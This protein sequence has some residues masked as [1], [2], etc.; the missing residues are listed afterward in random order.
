MTPETIQSAIEFYHSVFVDRLENDPD[1]ARRFIRAVKFGTPNDVVDSNAL[2]FDDPNDTYRKDIEA[3]L[4]KYPEIET[5]P[6]LIAV[7]DYEQWK[8]NPTS[9]HHE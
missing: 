3:I 2:V 4:I 8:T 5:L 7:M 9:E 1:A 6:E